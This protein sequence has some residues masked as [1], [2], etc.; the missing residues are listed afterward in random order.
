[1]GECVYVHV[2]RVCVHVDFDLYVD[3]DGKIDVCVYAYMYMS[4]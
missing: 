4:M 2:L 1:M 3:V